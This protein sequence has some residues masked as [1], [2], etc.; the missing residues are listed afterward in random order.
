MTMEGEEVLRNGFDVGGC[1]GIRSVSISLIEAWHEWYLGLEWLS[2][3][4][5]GETRHRG[6]P[7][8]RGRFTRQGNRCQN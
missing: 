8:L 3:E 1:R 2:D 4:G 6:S 7:Y 5:P